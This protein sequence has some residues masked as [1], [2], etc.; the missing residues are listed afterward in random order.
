MATKLGVNTLES[1][2]LRLDLEKYREFEIAMGLANLGS[3]EAIRQTIESTMNKFNQIDLTGLVIKDEFTPKVVS[4]KGDAFPELVGHLS[5][6]VTAP[7]GLGQDRLN[8]LVFVLPEFFTDKSEPY[9][10]DN[11]Y[12]Q[13]IAVENKFITSKKARP[14]NVLSFRLVKGKWSGSL[15]NYS[16]TS[17]EDILFAVTDAM[18]KHIIATIKCELIDLLPLSRHLTPSEVEHLNAIHLGPVASN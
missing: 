9:R 12:Y 16:D 2:T 7:N 17:T 6:T 15:F 4:V 1:V 10:V 5:L 18:K 3:A 8:E 11:A 14:R 13:R